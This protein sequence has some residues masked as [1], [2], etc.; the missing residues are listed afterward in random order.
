M[1]N[2]KVDFGQKSAVIAYFNR[3]RKYCIEVFSNLKYA[4]IFV[5]F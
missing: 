1:Q 2:Q 3:L 4:Q 5:S